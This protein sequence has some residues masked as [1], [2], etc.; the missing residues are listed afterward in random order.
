VNLLFYVSI[1]DQVVRA[2][3]KTKFSFCLTLLS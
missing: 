3:V 1:D 2:R